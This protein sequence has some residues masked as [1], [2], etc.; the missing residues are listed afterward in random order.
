MADKEIVVVRESEDNPSHRE[1]SDREDEL[2]DKQTN[3]N[4]LVQAIVADRGFFYRFNISYIVQL[5]LTYC[6]VDAK[7][8]RQGL[9]TGKNSNNGT[10]KYTCSEAALDQANIFLIHTQ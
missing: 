6:N 7:I 10:P 3:N 1:A 2:G 4:D 5:S 9:P 8:Q